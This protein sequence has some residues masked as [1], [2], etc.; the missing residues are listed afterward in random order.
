MVLDS[1]WLDGVE[2]R[3][4]ETETI[5]A[6]KQCGLGYV[7]PRLADQP[8]LNPYSIADE[9]DYFSATQTS[10]LAAF[11]HLLKQVPGWLGRPPE[12][13]L[14]IGCGD[15]TLLEA[16]G[17]LGVQ[18]RLGLEISE[19]LLRLVEERLGADLASAKPL[20]SLPSAQFDVVAL[21]NVL[22]HLRQPL[23]MLQSAH[24]R[25]KPGGIMLVHVPN[26]GGLP[27]RLRG[28]R[29]HQIEPYAHFYYFTPGVLKD[30][31]ARA[32]LSPIGRFYLPKGD[33][34]RNTAQ[35]IIARIGLEVD[36]GLG[37]VA[38]RLLK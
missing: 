16:A 18:T 38:Q 29:W 13:L 4:A 28:P 30:M 25:L 26:F 14:D 19:P 1:I 11:H 27:A 22:E 8:G 33:S 15:G 37:V 36:N 21:I 2:Q 31:L 7:N 32:G 34:F 17:N 23:E 5:V 12:S 6:C 3:L 9:L 20:D 35:K 24:D 10:R